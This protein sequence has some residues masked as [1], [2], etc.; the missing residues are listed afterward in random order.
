VTAAR[1]LLCC[2]DLSETS[3]PALEEALRLARALRVPLSV[4]H[5]CPPRYPDAG[6]LGLTVGDADLLDLAG[7]RVRRAA[8]S[9]LGALV[10]ETK[11][12]LQLGPVPVRTLVREGL[13][14]KVI[15]EEAEIEEA[16]LIVVGTHA[17]SGLPA[18]LLGS[19]AE[20]VMRTATRPVLTVTPA[21][22]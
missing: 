22:R 8:E 20:R 12:A 17:R 5:V 6:Y 21:L 16:E 14:A 3:R 2:T 11:E 13:P 4:L 18:L 19:V 7:D 15:V 9:S 1:P 10:S